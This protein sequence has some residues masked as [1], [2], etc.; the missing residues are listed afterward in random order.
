QA[1]LLA[2]A[3]QYIRRHLANGELDATEIASAIVCSSPM[4]HQLFAQ[5]ELTVEGYIHEQ[6]LQQFLRLL[7]K[8]PYHI[9]IHILAQR[10]GLYD[11]RRAS[12]AF[13]KRVGMTPSDARNMPPSAYR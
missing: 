7:Q 10:C 12:R 5:N 13:R 6:R 2:A 3:Q 9:P 11:A 8:E 1:A 4:L